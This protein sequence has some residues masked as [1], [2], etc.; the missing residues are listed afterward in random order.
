M[1]MA[2]RNFRYFFEGVKEKRSEIS[3]KL[4]KKHGSYSSNATGEVE[5]ECRAT[6]LL[7][8]SLPCS[9]LS[10][11]PLFVRAL[12]C[13]RVLYPFSYNGGAGEMKSGEYFNEARA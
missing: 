5:D 3:S 9:R 2:M 8:L 12:T 13:T 7:A 10:G 1:T 4:T 6:A 11:E